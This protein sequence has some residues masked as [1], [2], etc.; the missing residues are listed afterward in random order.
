MKG[1]MIK[2]FINLQ[3]TLK[4]L[5][6]IMAL[7]MVIFLP[8]GNA[9]FFGVL[10]MMMTMM[11]VT[12]ISYDDLAKWDSYALTMPVSRKEVVTSKYVVML[13]LDGL[14][15]AMA[16]I[17]GLI[18]VMILKNSSWEE[19]LAVLVIIASIGLIAGST[20]LPLIYYFGT[21][22]ARIIIILVAMVP[23]GLVLLLSGML[24][25]QQWQW[26]TNIGADISLS[27]IIIGLAV[28]SAFYVACSYMISKRIYEKK[29]F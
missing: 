17:V 12:T 7:W 26:L 9:T 20:M 22:K 5:L 29:E 10:I 25:E 3:T 6:P 13:L 16:L 8:N 14:G 27:M 19:M 15:V 21:E 2:D 23:T 18:G 1:L 28:F 11:V 24:S 4:R